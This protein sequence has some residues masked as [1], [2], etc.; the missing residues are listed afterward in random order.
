MCLFNKWKL[1]V[2]DKAH[3]SIKIKTNS[4]DQASIEY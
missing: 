1:N 3:N 4:K 2:D